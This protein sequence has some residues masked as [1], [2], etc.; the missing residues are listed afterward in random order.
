MADLKT[1]EFQKYFDG[2]DCR[3]QEVI[4]DHVTENR[5]KVTLPRI[6]P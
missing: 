5:E 4:P 3:E 1:G 2:K 6:F